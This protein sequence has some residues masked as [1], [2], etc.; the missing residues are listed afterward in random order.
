MPG[1]KISKACIISS[2]NLC[3]PPVTYHQEQNQY[4]HITQPLKINGSIDLNKY[5]CDLGKDSKTLINWVLIKQVWIYILQI[6]EVFII[7]M[8]SNSTMQTKPQR[9]LVSKVGSEFGEI[10]FKRWNIECYCDLCRQ[11]QCCVTLLCFWCFEWYC[12][13]MILCDI[14]TFQRDMVD[15]QLWGDYSLKGV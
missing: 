10:A 5:H 9:K 12:S 4:I 14:L 13:F 7:Q 1:L 11:R 3:V 2:L 15:W 6:K 8:L